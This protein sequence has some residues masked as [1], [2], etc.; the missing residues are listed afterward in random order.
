MKLSDVGDGL[1]PEQPAGESSK[2]NVDA[3]DSIEIELLEVLEISKTCLPAIQQLQ[4]E[5]GQILEG[6]KG[7]ECAKVSFEK[8]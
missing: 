4:V 1:A 8:K 3:S 7:T 2:I 5:Q 6:M